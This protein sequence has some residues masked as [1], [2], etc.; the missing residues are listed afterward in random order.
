MHEPTRHEVY[1]FFFNTRVGGSGKEDYCESLVH[2]CKGG[3]A[4]SAKV[5]VHP[6]FLPTCLRTGNF[7]KQDLI[8]HII[9]LGLTSHHLWNHFARLRAGA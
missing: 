2:V 5:S 3:D 6:V 4:T 8:V 7:G 1:I 9:L